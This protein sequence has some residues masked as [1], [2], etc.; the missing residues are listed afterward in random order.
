MMGKPSASATGVAVWTHRYRGLQ[1]IVVSLDGIGST[2]AAHTHE[3]RMATPWERACSG[4]S[5]P[6]SRFR[7]WASSLAWSTPC[8]DK[9]G[10]RGI[11]V[12]GVHS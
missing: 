12:G 5:I 1:A 7:N 3:L 9:G 11:P 2:H 10:S 6:R 4:D 8:L